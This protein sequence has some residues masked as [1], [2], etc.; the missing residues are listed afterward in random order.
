MKIRPLQDRLLV[1][2]VPEPEATEPIFPNADGKPRYWF[3]AADVLRA[4]LASVDC[5]TEQN[6]HAITAKSL[7]R[8]FATWLGA[9][10]VEESVIGRLMG[11][12]AKTVTSRHYT[13]AD[14]ERLYRAVCSIRLDGHSEERRE[15][16]ERATRAAR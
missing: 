3:D 1:K 8:S 14:L 13:A 9:A 16:R 11:H 12:T 4:D 5:A 10:G 6:G 7:R 2:R 15:R